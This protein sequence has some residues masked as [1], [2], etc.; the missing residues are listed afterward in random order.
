VDSTLELDV[1][2]A[3]S[4][5]TYT[6]LSAELLLQGDYSRSGD[7]LIIQSDSGEEVV[8]EG[9]FLNATPPILQTPAG[10]ALLPET[11]QQLI[12]NTVAVD[13]AGPADSLRIPGAL[14]SSIGVIDDIGADANV[15]AKGSD[16]SIRTL[17]AGDS[18][19]Q[20][21]VV[22]TV[23]RSY[24]GIR[25]NDDTS[26]QLGK[27]TRAVI[28]NYKYDDKTEAGKFEATVTTGFFRYAS[29]KL[30]GLNKGTHSTIKTPTAQIGIR[31]SELEGQ[32]DRDGST[33]FVH[34]SGILDVSDVFG[35][36]TVTL[37]QPGTATAV[38]FKPG[39]PSP[40]FEAPEALMSSFKSSMPSVPQFVVMHREE[41]EEE[42]V[43]E[44]AGE[45]EEGEEG[46]GEEEMYQKIYGKRQRRILKEKA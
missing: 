7:N 38:S 6:I 36:G 5:E 40:I 27:E 21:D 3:D 43:E 19:Y 32:V 2:T 10:A 34:K 39:A 9:Y 22:E 13:V 1:A 28:D 26:F 31:G 37:T 42:G 46:E 11:V 25:M 41:E 23:G 15:T 4:A 45:E 44:E 30:G 18:I 8:V 16:G 20:G 29:G 14:G 24:A 12:V 35:R 33:T 17:K